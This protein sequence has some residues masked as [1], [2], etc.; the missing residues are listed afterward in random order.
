MAPSPNA[1]GSSSPNVVLIDVEAEDEL[2]EPRAKTNTAPKKTNASKTAPTE[3]TAAVSTA[4]SATKENVQDI[5]KKTGPRP[6][7]KTTRKSDSILAVGAEKVV[8]AGSSEDPVIP[9]SQ[10]SSASFDLS[11]PNNPLSSPFANAPLPIL[12]TE[13]E[14][15]PQLTIFDVLDPA[16]MNEV[17]ALPSGVDRL[18][19]VPPSTQHGL[20]GPMVYPRLAENPATVAPPAPVAPAGPVA[21]T[22]PVAPAGPVAPTVPVAPAAPTTPT[23]SPTPTAPPVPSVVD[24]PASDAPSW[25]QDQLKKLQQVEIDAALHASWAKCL[26]TWISLERAQGFEGKV[27]ILSLLL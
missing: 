6:R 23:A 27:R 26:G 7:P 12:S 24:V 8:A 4:P 13:A 17:P 18:T 11:G 15:A 20:Y 22:A 1:S 25:C 19:L 3:K 2:E 16:L 5:P 9:A 14:H 10:A 21:P